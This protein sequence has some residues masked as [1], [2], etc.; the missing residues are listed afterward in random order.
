MD[1]SFIFHPCMRFSPCVLWLCT[2]YPVQHWRCTCQKWPL[3][4]D[5]FWRGLQWFQICIMP[6]SKRLDMHSSNITANKIMN[7]HRAPVA[8]N[9]SNQGQVWMHTYRV[10]NIIYPNI[11]PHSVAETFSKCCIKCPFNLHNY[12]SYCSCNHTVLPYCVCA[13]VHTDSDVPWCKWSL[14]H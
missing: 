5:S 6:A 13:H 11:F 2:T 4:T 12:Y 9:E 1:K 10:K 7:H 3:A 14:T 8:Q